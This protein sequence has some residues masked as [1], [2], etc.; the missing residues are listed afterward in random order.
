MQRALGLTEGLDA[1]D[2][3]STATVTTSLSVDHGTR[4]I[5]RSEQQGARK[6]VGASQC[7]PA[8]MRR[9]RGVPDSPGDPSRDGAAVALNTSEPANLRVGR[10]HGRWRT[11]Q[12]AL[13]DRPDTGR[14][15][16]GITV[17]ARRSTQGPNQR[18][19]RASSRQAKA[20]HEGVGDPSKGLLGGVRGTAF[21][22][23]DVRLVDAG[24]LGQLRPG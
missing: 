11:R 18:G 1:P 21:D 7:V 9:Q 16:Q 5:R 23:S 13:P 17:T 2:G 15:V 6:V 3:P 20:P 19:G 10:A 24:P 8:R 12:R 22:P 14:C 4:A